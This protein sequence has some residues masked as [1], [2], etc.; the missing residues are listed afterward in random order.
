[1][2]TLIKYSL[3]AVISIIANL[4]S[5]EL[6][7]NLYT[8][9][10]EL[11]LAIFVGTLVGLVVKYLLDKYFIFYYQSDSSK[12]NMKVFLLYSLMSVFTTLIFWGVEFTFDYIFQTKFMRYLGGTIGLIL[13]YLI[14]YQ[15]D[16][17]YV[18]KGA[19]I[20]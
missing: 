19:V 20:D 3:F 13:G 2:K 11:P 6:T 5:Q 14:K 16:K 9:V 1:M 8:G 10:W 18:F 4:S 17:K 12:D 15:L 7:V